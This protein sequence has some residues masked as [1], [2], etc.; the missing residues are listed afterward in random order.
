MKTEIKGKK[1]Q[2]NKTTFFISSSSRASRLPSLA[3]K[4]PKKET[5]VMQADCITNAV[6]L[7]LV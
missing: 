2:Q 1:Q 7:M 3:W 4:T 6:G 5:P